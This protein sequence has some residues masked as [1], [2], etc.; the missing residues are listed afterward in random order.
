MSAQFVLH[1]E[2]LRLQREE[3]NN[4]FIP[5]EV[6]IQGKTKGELTRYLN[7][8]TDRIEV[9]SDGIC[10]PL[11]F[12]KIR[13]FLKNF[14]HLPK[15]TASKV[16]DSLLSAFRAQ[17]RSTA[18]DLDRNE[19]DMFA[20][21]R[22]C[23]ERYGFLVHWIL[24][25]SDESSTSSTTASGKP[26]KGKSRA[27][28]QIDWTS[29][30]IKAFDF[31]ARLLEIKMSK[32]WALTPERQTFIG[33]FTKPAFQIFE[34]PATSKSQGKEIKARA[35]RVLGLSIKYYDYMFGA[36]TT[37]MQNLQYWEHSA[38]PMAELLKYMIDK[39]DYTQLTDE[40]LREISNKDF[41]DVSSKEVKD[42]PNAKTFAAFLV[43]LTELS[44][45]TVLKNLGLL[46]HQLGSESYTMRMAIIEILGNLIVELTKHVDDN[47]A[48]KDQINGFFDI[49]EER[50]LDPIAFVRSKVLQTYLRI[51]DI[52][53]KF[54]KRRYALCVLS[55]RHLQDK[56][57]IV[58][59]YAIRVLT[60]LVVTHPFS[61]YGGELDLESW[62]AKLDKLKEEIEGVTTEDDIPLPFAP[63]AVVG[64]EQLP[65]SNQVA[66]KEPTAE[67]GQSDEQS[68][69]KEN[70]ADDSDVEME[71]TSEEATNETAQ[72]EQREE[73]AQQ[74]GPSP[75]DASNKAVIS[76]EKMQQ[77]TL[78]KTFHADA[79]KFIQQ[80]HA[81]M[82]LIFQLL[83]SKS[84]PEVLEAMEFLVTA[85]E[86]KI[87]TASEGIRKML[88]L[89]WTK[90][91]SDEGKG[92]KMKLLECYRKL[93]LD[94][95]VRRTPRE[96][97]NTITRNLIQLT[98]NTTLAELTS[99]EQL[100]STVMAEDLLGENV[101][102]KLWSVYGFTSGNIPKE[103]RRGAI[104][105]LGMLAKARTEIVTEKV[106]ALLRIG[107]GQL[108]KSD[109]ALA[110]YTCI[111]LQR[112]AG[113]SA[114]AGIRLP[115]S[116]A[117]FGRL[118]DMIESPSQEMEWFSMTEQAINA[119]YM[120]GEHPDVLCG[121]IIRNKTI[122]VFGERARSESPP[123][124]DAMEVDYDMSISQQ[125][126]P[127]PANPIHQSA[128]ELSQLLFM[129]GH[130]ALKQIVH[131]EIIEAA[132]KK[133]KAKTDDKK[134]VEEEL[135]QVGGTAEDDIGDTITHIREREVLFGANSLLARYGPLI[136]EVCARN[137][138]YTDRTL[139]MTATLALGKF[140]CVSSDY[141]EKNLQLLFTILEKS[142]D[143]TIRSNI[144]IALGDMAVCFN[145]LIDENISFLYNRLG[146]ENS[147]VK[148]NAV[149]V[150]T[151]LIL[152]G[153]VKVKGQISEM[154]KCLEDPD[155]RIADL[156]KLFFTELATKDNAIY[157]NLPDIIS[158]LT[159]CEPKVDE[160]IFRRIMRFVFSFEFAEKEKQAENVV[161]KL[162]QRF[163]NTDDER[164]WR[165]IAFCLSL[166]PFKSERSFRKLL[167]GLPTYQDKLHVES[168][169]KS[170]QEIIAKGRLQKSAKPEL[171]S[172]LDELDQKIARK[173]G[174]T[175]E[176]TVINH[177]DAPKSTEAK[178]RVLRKRA[179]R[180]AKGQQQP[181]QQRKK[182]TTEAS[183][184]RRRR[185]ADSSEEEEEEE[186]M[187][188]DD[189]GDD[190]D[191]DDDGNDDDASSSS[192]D[193]PMAEDGNK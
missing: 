80:L 20:T 137:K 155:Q 72:N 31:I 160:E 15:E 165:D 88:H 113:R 146:D 141:C 6:A 152:N 175:A 93:Y 149:M 74:Q 40:I 170:F 38:E 117:V 53:T 187:E 63:P 54:P 82:P 3:S 123:D 43:K 52:K 184:K 178:T 33:L 131:L 59:K 58:R 115:M 100:L 49:L 30:K 75:S 91:T 42:S 190:D 13:S 48:Q 16:M 41:K 138:I 62:Q 101:I 104:I 45:K 116:H 17:V 189:D 145:T 180:A 84:K 172:V 37:I 103:Q 109:L 136:T 169:H 87:S 96:N 23:L 68:D 112:L 106:D 126:L 57:S 99:L 81:S 9:E 144:V 186:E 156:A 97:I 56:S 8:I 163:A 50:M 164:I 118:K 94:P 35:F 98:Y 134:V 176:E 188:L 14:Q 150:L 191:D 107:L 171:K 122:K 142:K 167:E 177:G 193:E 70:G 83:S 47:P 7:D 153:M 76:A 1:E 78:M 154:A 166:L 161:D 5:N 147:L 79:V 67:K 90:D 22:Q 158:N 95:D 19:K 69:P 105:I 64:K 119:I 111:A 51:L 143:A 36:Q 77:L 32:L 102:D 92:V 129:V 168:V 60:K 44:P 86:Y 71:E 140:M 21:H 183:R 157:N 55:V 39:Q 28:E 114:H 124:E 127:Y 85:Y 34:D 27:S 162:C 128:M 139:Q 25:V 26:K 135:E 132:W 179:P 182:S 46:I 120:L 130:V 108:G 12:D 4:Y 110:R 133:K 10:D 159:N 174:E 11:V 2:V 73:P 24:I 66:D 151:H 181:Q 125:A 18:E 61:M 89:I 148:K 185:A 29:H 173:S 192:S 65:E 121:E